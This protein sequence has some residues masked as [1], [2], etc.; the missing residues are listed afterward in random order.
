MPPELLEILEEL[1]RS[2][3]EIR[4]KEDLRRA[5]EARP[6]LV[7]KWMRAMQGSQSGRAI[8]A[9][10]QED[11]QI[12]QESEQRYLRNGDWEALNRAVEAWQRILGNPSFPQAPERFRL[13]VLNG[14]G[15]VF[16]RR[17]RRE[18]S[19]RIWIWPCNAI[20]SRWH[21]RRRIRPTCHFVST[22][23]ASG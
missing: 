7:E 19:C 6:D 18:V 3:V 17:Y 20:S 9:E 22:I 12:A 1:A 10:F 23:W 21:P 4:S 5:L 13:E 2:G 11:I 14:A 16:S 8:P 15:I